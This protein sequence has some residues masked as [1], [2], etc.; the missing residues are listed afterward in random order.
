MGAWDWDKR[1]NLLQWSSEHFTIMGLAPFSV[2]P[3]HETWVER[4]HPDDVAFARAAM[5]RAIAEGSHY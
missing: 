2:R 5:E 1:N 3:T 4:V